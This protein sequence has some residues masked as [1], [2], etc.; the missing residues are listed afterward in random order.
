[1]KNTKRILII[2]FGGLGDIF[3]SLCAIYS[4]VSHHKKKVVLL[5]ENP[6]HQILIKSKWFEEIVVM[7]RSFFYFF[8]KIQ[9]KKKLDISSFDCVYDLQ[10]SKRSSSYLSL[11]FKLGI[12]TSGIGNYASFNH[13]N[14]QRDKMHT[15]DR[16][17][18]QLEIS[19]IKYLKKIDLKWLFKSKRIDFTHETKYS[20]IVPGGSKKRKNK[21]IP[22]EVFN[23]IIKILLG[24]KIIPILIGSSDDKEICSNLENIHPNVK[25]LCTKTDIF[26]I[27]KLSE[28]SIISIGNDTGPMH[29]IANGNMPTF[30]FFTKYSD[31]KLCA[32]VGK[33]VKIFNYENNIEK[34]CNTIKKEINAFSQKPQY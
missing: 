18:E 14:T 3:L 9:I 20:L 32:P 7:K 16:Q 17:R 12:K 23:Q 30:V 8:D 15:L 11:F 24:K 19:S 31:P 34:F 4:I 6:Y 28:N 21:R 29:V 2:K 25:N 13:T 33:N 10:T 5:T 26:D 22:F 27:A 1:M